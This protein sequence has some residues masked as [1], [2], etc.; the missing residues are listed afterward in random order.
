MAS[1]LHIFKSVLDLFLLHVKFSP[2]P[3]FLSRSLQC[4]PCLLVTKVAE[5]TY[6]ISIY[7]CTAKLHL[8]RACKTVNWTPV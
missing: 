3:P 8:L 7:V 2:S 6:M 5:D 1:G 4:R